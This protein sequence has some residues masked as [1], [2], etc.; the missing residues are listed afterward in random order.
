MSF[1]N[2]K[3]L[4][5]QTIS[6]W[7]SRLL[8]SNFVQP[9]AFF[10]LAFTAFYI[11]YSINLQIYSER[12]ISRASNWLAGNFYWPGPEMSGGNNLPGPFFYFLLFPAFLLGENTYSQVILWT[13]SWLS[14][15][16]TITFF[17]IS[18]I[19]SYKE[20]L[21]IFLINFI[22]TLYATEYKTTLNPE[23]AIMFHVFSFAGLYYWRL[24]KDDFYLY[25]TGLIIALGVQVHLLIS[26]YILTVLLFYIIDKSTRKKLKALLYF[27]LL[28]FSPMLIYLLLKYLHVFETSE[29]YYKEYFS[30][31]LHDI[32]TEMWFNYVKTLMPFILSLVFCG[33]I[34]LWKKFKTKR[35]PL[36]Q[37]TK[38]LLSV[39][40]IPSLIAILIA[41][42]YWYLL[43]MPACLSILISK[44]MDDLMPA[45]KNLRILSL[46][47]YSLFFMAYILTQHHGAS[48]D[49]SSFIE[50][51]FILLLSCLSIML[52]V[53]LQWRKYFFYKMALACLYTALFIQ[54][55]DVKKPVIHL[56]PQQAFSLQWSGFHYHYHYPLM[57]RIY[58]ETGWPPKTAMKKIFNLGT[59]PSRN[60]LADY[61]MTVEKLNK[62]AV[63]HKKQI[64]PE[65]ENN[66]TTNKP[67]GYFMIQ[68]LQ[69]FEDYTQKDWK[70]YLT[71]SS[72]LPSQL[73]QEIKTNKMTL[74]EPKLYNAYWLIP[75]QTTEESLFPE[76]FH[77]VE[78]SYYWEEPE[79][80][81]K[82]NETQVFKNEKELFYCKVLPGYLQK[83]GVKIKPYHVNNRS[84]LNISFFGPALGIIMQS[85]N[86]N[87]GLSWTNIHIHIDCAKQT[88]NWSLPNVG[89][90]SWDAFY[91]IEKQ[92]KIL[93]T[94]LEVRVSLIKCKKE[95][96]NKIQLTFTENHLYN[97]I[98]KKETVVWDEISFN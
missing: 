82:C 15:T 43:F 41:R 9:L 3:Q 8:N 28:A 96:I 24:K 54:A 12:D 25:L 31:I 75:Y 46:L 87:G 53:I 34:T 14:L 35:W 20:S 37:S 27:L 44:W 93:L 71:K 90:H 11:G 45:K 29:N 2:K 50:N 40:A 70:N 89:Y 86:K 56:E 67:Q 17:F 23:F 47:I 10:C 65:Q 1:F 85:S 73:V 32:F 98:E 38:D 79:W 97:S 80:L 84:F 66:L 60:L 81:K 33:T 4:L 30:V 83:A 61:I 57:E 19:I 72:L 7:S 91:S 18:K 21:L 62:T 5:F 74:Q 58:I 49:F 39:I 22:L 51:K 26:L 69:S 64:Y 77:N 94:P 63:S 13:V 52:I 95:D 78:Q 48:L 76:G 55:I 42:E 92:A 88:F 6:I 59:Y 68:N 36:T 16:Y